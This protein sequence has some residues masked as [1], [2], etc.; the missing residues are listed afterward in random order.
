MTIPSETETAALPEPSQELL[1]GHPKGLYVLFL[2]EMWERFSYYGMR[3][4]LILYLVQ[5]LRF[6]DEDAFAIY[7]SFTALVFILPVF[8]GWIADRY[9]GFRKAVIFGG[10]LMVAGHIGMAFEGSPAVAQLQENG[11]LLVYRDEVSLQIFYLSLSL[12]IC[13]VGFLKPNITSIVGLLYPNSEFQR[14]KGFTIFSM[15]IM[16]GAAIAPIACGYLGQ[17]YGWRYGFGLAGIGMLLGLAVFI[18]GQRYLVG[19]AERPE[20]SMSGKNSYFGLSTDHFIYLITLLSV[21]AIWQTIQNARLVAILLGT[22]LVVVFVGL[23]VFAIWRLDKKDR[24]RTL[25]ALLVFALTAL[26]AVYIE[27]Y[28]SSLILFSERAVDRTFLGIE[29]Q[30]SQ[31]VGGLPV[32]L[33]L[34]APAFVWLWGYLDRHRINPP[35]FSKFGLAFIILGVAFAVL[36]LGTT[37]PDAD[38]KVGLGW[39]V[40]CFFILAVSDFWII[41]IGMS[42]VSKLS[43]KIMV[44][45]MMGA[46]ML[47]L[48]GGYYMSAVVAKY[49]LTSGDATEREVLLQYQQFFVYIAA[50]AA[51]IGLVIMVLAPLIRKHMHGVN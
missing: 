31:L 13:G 26:Y 4:L 45:L 47:A 19:I 29:I 36:W 50:S 37:M 12:L 40:L 3:A 17:T 22:Q 35:S 27:Q 5:H 44:G 11:E 38:Q 9:L 34:L 1:F 39:L 33:V 28:G 16:V 46:Y 43:A 20:P 25:V 42:V 51:L 6:V 24:D 21:F 30:S 32:F 49:S 48:S 10:L 15:G 8:G 23:A 7:G 41:P 18:Y 2:T 14:D